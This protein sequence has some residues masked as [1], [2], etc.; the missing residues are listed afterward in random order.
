MDRVAWTAWTISSAALST[1]TTA[2]TMCSI[3]INRITF[4]LATKFG[5]DLTVCPAGRL[6]WLISKEVVEPWEVE[7]QDACMKLLGIRKFDAVSDVVCQPLT[8]DYL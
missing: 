2:A 5:N 3:D 8:V 1:L 7:G 4:G 6:L